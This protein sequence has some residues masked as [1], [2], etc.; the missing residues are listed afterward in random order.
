MDPIHHGPLGYLPDL[1]YVPF[2]CCFSARW[3]RAEARTLSAHAWNNANDA[4]GFVKTYEQL[5]ALRFCLGV[6]DNLS[7]HPG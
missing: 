3:G 7:S 5:L 1:Q 6:S 4:V 2:F